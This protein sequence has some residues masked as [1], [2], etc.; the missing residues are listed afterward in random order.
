M[1]NPESFKHLNSQRSD[2]HDLLFLVTSILLIASTVVVIIGCSR[3][4]ETLPVDIELKASADNQSLLDAQLSEPLPEPV[5][6]SIHNGLV[7]TSLFEIAWARPD[8]PDSIMYVR[9]TI[10]Y[11]IWNKTYL[12]TTYR[13]DDVRKTFLYRDVL[14][15]DAFP[16]N[17]YF[18][19]LKQ[20]PIP[21]PADSTAVRVRLTLTVDEIEDSQIYQSGNRKMHL[22]PTTPEA[23]LKYGL[24]KLVNFLLGDKALLTYDSGWQFPDRIAGE[25]S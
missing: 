25:A 10:L 11:D 17:D 3:A 22:D 6:S 2:Y 23:T 14:S 20:I 4:V 18:A 12:L 1:S 15:N 5:K 8:A 19:H 9:Q 7:S 16:L 21:L 13:Q 24:D